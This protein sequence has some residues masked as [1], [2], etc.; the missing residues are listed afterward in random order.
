M[1]FFEKVYTVTTDTV[2]FS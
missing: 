1:L 2:A